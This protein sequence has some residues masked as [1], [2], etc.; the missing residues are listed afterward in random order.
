M[1][2]SVLEQYHVA[3]F[4]DWHEQ[5]RLTLNP[6]FQRRSVWT[7][8][9]KSYLID[10]ILRGLPMPK[11]YMRTVIDV[12]SQSSVR[13]IV[14][15]QQRIAAILDFAKGHL[16]LNKRAGE[17]AG[18]RYEDIDE[19]TKQR[20][21]SYAISV[22]QLINASDDEVLQ[23][24]ARLNS[25]TV[26]LNQAELRN[27][28]YQGDFKWKVRE[29]ATEL[30]D[31][32]KKYAIL[33]TRDRLRML[34]DQLTAEMFGVS[35]EGV[36]DGG[37]PS[38]NK[39]YD[40]YDPS[41][42]RADEIASQVKN[43][44]EFTDT[45]FHEA[46]RGGVFSRPPQVLMLFAAIAHML[47]GIPKG[48]IGGQLPTRGAD[49]LADLDLARTNLA[50]LTEAVADGSVAGRFADFVKASSG[51]TQRIA[52]RRVRFLFLWRALA[53]PI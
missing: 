2:K 37:Q 32:W 19:E 46:M 9:G 12:V 25:Y 50:L 22:D 29:V 30:G 23:V 6:D 16:R 53:E 31:F 26:P 44:V 36:R 3:D 27:A 21:L 24:F 39:L 51:S 47:H 15:G 42:P 35:L 28:K 14:D 7:P 43:V 52:S 18:L 34:D 33:S 5:K 48:D 41:F 17:Y 11:I 8:D 40:R 4:I 1:V 20:F 45:E 49:P 10:T 38:I 13:D